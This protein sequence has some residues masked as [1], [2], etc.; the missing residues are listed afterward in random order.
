MWIFWQVLAIAI[1]SALFAVC[2]YM[3]LNIWSYL[4]YAGVCLGFTAWMFPKAYE[5]APTYF[6]AYWVGTAAFTLFTFIITF[7]V[8]HENISL[9]N[10]LGAIGVVLCSI[11][12]V[13]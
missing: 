6:Q 13:I 5:L 3:G 11:L 10:I 8:F 1:T 9:L 4:I 2:R 7:L 12:V